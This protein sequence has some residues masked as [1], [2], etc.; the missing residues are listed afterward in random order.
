MKWLLLLGLFFSL[1][2]RASFYFFST[3]DEKDVPGTYAYWKYGTQAGSR[4]YWEKGTGLGSRHFWQFGKTIGSQDYWEHGTCPTEDALLPKPPCPGTRD[5]W[6]RGTGIG[7]RYLWLLGTNT[8][9]TMYYW[10]F[11]TEQSFDHITVA[12]CLGGALKI[13]P[14]KQMQVLP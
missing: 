14:C 13:E 7:S 3:V 12:L 1:E 4:E 10:V 5:Y 9:G 6:E 8:P 11:G 2:T